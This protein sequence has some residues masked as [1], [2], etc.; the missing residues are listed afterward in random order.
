MKK[1][2][3]GIVALAAVATACQPEKIERE[4]ESLTPVTFE[5]VAMEDNFWLPRLK[6][7]KETL[8]PYSL[9]KVEHAVRNLQKV[10][11]Y[12]NGKEQNRAIKQ[13]RLQRVFVVNL[14]PT[15]KIVGNENTFRPNHITHNVHTTVHRNFNNVLTRIAVRRTENEKHRLVNFPVTLGN[16]AV[17]G[18]VAL[19]IRNAFTRRGHK[20]F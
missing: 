16:I 11:D 4:K 19:H 5:K 6:T 3:F 15:P 8:V 12:R 20:Y 2:L 9:G 10:I 7:Q 18:C 1:T 17:C 13:R 14:Y